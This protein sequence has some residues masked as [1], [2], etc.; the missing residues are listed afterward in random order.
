M[1]VG[2]CLCVWVGADSRVV[3]SR[4]KPKPRALYQ[5]SGW[6]FWVTKV[7]WV[8]PMYPRDFGFPVVA[9]H[10][11][12]ICRWREAPGEHAISG[13]SQAAVACSIDEKG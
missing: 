7:S 1:D 9:A 4:V 13:D 5:S 3:G 2:V 12:G 6:V 10:G 8:R 11:T